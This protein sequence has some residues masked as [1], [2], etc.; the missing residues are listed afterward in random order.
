MTF[1][2]FWAPW[3]FIDFPQCLGRWSTYLFLE[4]NNAVRVFLVQTPAEGRG[5]FHKEHGLC[6]FGVQ[7]C[8]RSIRTGRGPKKRQNVIEAKP[9]LFKIAPSG[10]PR[11]LMPCS[12]FSCLFFSLQVSSLG[13]LVEFWWCFGW[14]GPQMCLFSPSGCRVEAAKDT[15]RFREKK[16]ENVGGRRKKKREILGPPTLWAPTLRASTL[17]APTL[18]GPTF[19]KFGPPPP[20][21]PH[22]R[23][24]VFF[25]SRCHFLFCPKCLL[26]FCPQCL[27]FCPVRFFLSRGRGDWWAVSTSLNV[28]NDNGG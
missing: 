7:G 4:Q 15:R 13:V 6:P 3:E 28:T 12:F 26:K 24:H 20:S 16:N 5:R 21:T 8:G 14:S 17:R 2:A 18:R 1:W 19:S 23:T 27:F 22:F 9:H 25:L 10:V 11:T